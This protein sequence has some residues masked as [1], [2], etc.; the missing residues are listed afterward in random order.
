MTRNLL[1]SQDEVGSYLMKQHDKLRT[2][3]VLC[4]NQREDLSSVLLIAELPAGWGSRVCLDSDGSS[5]E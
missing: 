1:C 5:I 2:D 3:G 4:P